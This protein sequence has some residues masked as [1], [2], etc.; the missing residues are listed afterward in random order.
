MKYVL[1]IFYFNKI[2]NISLTQLL[3]PETMFPFLNKNTCFVHPT[4]NTKD[5][6]YTKDTKNTKD[7]KDT[8]SAPISYTFKHI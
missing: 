4:F 5:T 2:M 7:T 8:K 6:K 3:P 1:Y